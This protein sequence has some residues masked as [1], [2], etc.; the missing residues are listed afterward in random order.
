MQRLWGRGEMH[1][2]YWWGHLKNGCRLEDPGFTKGEIEGGHG[3]D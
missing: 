1:T 2:G 3:M